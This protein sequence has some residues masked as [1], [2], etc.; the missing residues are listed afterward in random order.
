MLKSSGAFLRSSLNVRFRKDA[1]TRSRIW[2]NLMRALME[3]LLN[4][5]GPFKPELVSEQNML[6]MILP[7][8]WRKRRPPQT[9]NEQSR[10]LGNHTKPADSQKPQGSNAWYSE[11]QN[12]IGQRSLSSYRSSF[13]AKAGSTFQGRSDCATPCRG[14]CCGRDGRKRNGGSS[15]SHQLRN[16]ALLALQNWH[17]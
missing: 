15:T 5:R 8:K 17:T 1:E 2:R 16:G 3:V 14:S 9:R 13:C 7:H 10:E 12:A 11:R 4:C 6:L